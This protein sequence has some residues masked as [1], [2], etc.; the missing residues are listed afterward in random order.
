MSHTQTFTETERAE[1]TAVTSERVHAAIDSGDIAKAH[2]LL[3]RLVEETRGIHDAYLQWIAG[4]QSFIYREMGFD[5]F[6]RSQVETFAYTARAWTKHALP[7]DA[8]FKDRVLARAFALRSHAT[9]LSFEEDDEKVTFTMKD[10]C[11]SGK[12]LLDM[13]FYD[14]GQGGERIKEARPLTFNREDFPV[15]CTHCS[16]QQIA[17]ISAGK[18]LTMA[19]VPDQNLRTGLCRFHVYKPGHSAPESYVDTLRQKKAGAER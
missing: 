14:E 3:D 8:P 9:G 15:H 5:A 18:P 17:N 10:G 7:P 6:E 16:L 11:A 2:A 4:M 19:T 13:G 12:R 1:M